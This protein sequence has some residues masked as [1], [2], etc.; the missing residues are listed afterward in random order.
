MQYPEVKITVPCINWK[1]PSSN[2][3]IPN[4]VAFS[5]TCCIRDKQPFYIGKC[6]G[7][8]QMNFEIYCTIII[9]AIIIQMIC[10]H[11]INQVNT[12]SVPL[13]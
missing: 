2:Y 1:T 6:S 4:L 10:S 12:T 8:K 13:S 9:K 5:G 7:S 11:I 3:F